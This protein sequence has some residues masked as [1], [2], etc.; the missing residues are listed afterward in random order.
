MITR[1][2]AIAGAGAMAITGCATTEQT[3]PAATAARTS[4]PA[5]PPRATR[6]GAASS[7]FE[8]T[9][10]PFPQFAE[11]PDNPTHRFG[12]ASW[13]DLISRYVIDFG[14][15]DRVAR[16]RPPPEIGSR[17]TKGHDSPY[18]AEGNRIPFSVFEDEDV[19][20]FVQAREVLEELGNHVPL[21]NYGWSDQLAYW[22]NLHNAALLE[23]LALRYPVPHPERMRV[24]PDDLPLH[25][26][27]LVT[28][29]GTPLSLRDIRVEIVYR[30]WRHPGAIYGFFL[31]CVGG[32]SIRRGAYTSE[33]ISRQLASSA[34]E[35]VNSLRGVEPYRSYIGVSRTYEEALPIFK[36]W[37][38]ELR[39]HLSEFAGDQVGEL[40]ATDKP[41]RIKQYD[42]RI[43]DLSGGETRISSV[44]RAPITAFGPSVNNPSQPDR[45]TTLASQLV[46]GLDHRSA[47]SSLPP[48][49]PDHANRTLR[50]RMEKFDNLRKRGRRRSGR[51]TIEDLPTE[52]VQ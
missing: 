45:I 23:Q 29:H 4:A 37:Q 41:L 31:G 32:P 25:D 47:S 49:L 50:E 40:L 24:G 27:K 38:T 8:T 3:S 34:N 22:L 9:P 52:P 20:R 16:R 48:G 13:D 5:T 10:G 33:G 11:I 28:I 18:R 42:T 6:P 30:Y 17:L 51:V 19:R 1:R 2:T 7:Y 46:A 14:P 43:A 44:S 26:A 39:A 35:F 36:D 15:S 12:F 21:S